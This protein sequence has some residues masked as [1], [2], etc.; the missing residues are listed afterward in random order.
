MLGFTVSSARRVAVGGLVVAFFAALVWGIEGRSAGFAPSLPVPAATPTAITRLPVRIESTYPVATWTV[1]RLGVPLV[2]QASAAQVWR[3][4][5]VV[6]S[7]DE[8]LVTA[9]A[10][11]AAGSGN[12][13]LR[14]TIGAL[15]PRLIWGDGDITTTVAI[16]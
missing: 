5:V 9:Q 8:L 7:G 10:T 4:E 12:H 1:S 15:P 16:P 3:G 13:C 6:A 11:A 14:L 2:A